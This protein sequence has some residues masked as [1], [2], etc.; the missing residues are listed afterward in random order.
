MYHMDYGALVYMKISVQSIALLFILQLL[1]QE[2]VF[3][4]SARSGIDFPLLKTGEETG[5]RENESR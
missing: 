3:V 2:Q 4:S 1:F 5:M